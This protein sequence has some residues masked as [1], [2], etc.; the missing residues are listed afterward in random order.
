MQDLPGANIYKH[1]ATDRRFATSQ[2]LPHFP[3]LEPRKPFPMKLDKWSQ[4]GLSNE[5]DH[6]TTMVFSHW[7]TW[8][9]CIG[10]LKKSN[11]L[12]YGTNM[13]TGSILFPSIHPTKMGRNTPAATADAFNVPLRGPTRC[14]HRDRWQVLNLSRNSNLN[15]KGWLG[16]WLKLIEIDGNW[17][18][19]MENYW[20]IDGTF[21]EHWWLCLY[22]W[23]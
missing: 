1:I 9:Y 11:E 8:V 22:D 20:N 18:T 13:D 5:L 17:W 12:D 4:G 7:I 10:F 3:R 21:L 2:I 15:V 14:M 23:T 6:G 16:N 19:L